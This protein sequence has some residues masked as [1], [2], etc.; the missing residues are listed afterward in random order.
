MPSENA[1][2]FR[3]SLSDLPWT[4]IAPGL[5]EKTHVS[6][7]NH[8]RIVEFSLSFQEPEWCLKRHAG[9]VM[10]G[11]IVVNVA[12]QRVTYRQGDVIDLPPG[13]RHR[14]HATVETAQ[15]FLIEAAPT[16]SAGDPNSDP[17]R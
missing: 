4:Q 12:G 8:F 9:F 16:D 11:E 17:S 7:S 5:R 14:H 6:G 2:P 1:P 13:V 3:F 15:L 10:S